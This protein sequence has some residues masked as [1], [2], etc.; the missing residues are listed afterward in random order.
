MAYTHFT[1]QEDGWKKGDSHKSYYQGS[2]FGNYQFVTLHDIVDNFMISYVGENKIIPTVRRF[3]VAFHA[4]RALQELSFD[5]LKSWKS[6]QI[7]LPPTLV[8]TLPHDYIAYTKISTVDSAGI[9]HPLYPT[10]H[11]SNPFQIMQ[12]E[13]GSYEFP[14]GVELVENGDYSDTVNTGWTRVTDGNNLP[15]LTG[16]NTSGPA[17]FRSCVNVEDDKLKWSYVTKNGQGAYN[18]SHICFVYQEINVSD[19]DYITLSADG[20]S[21]NVSYTA[22]DGTAGTLSST[23]R[24]GVTSTKPQDSEVKNVVGSTTGYPANPNANIDIFDLTSPES[25]DPTD[26]NYSAGGSH[27]E[28]SGDEAATKEIE[29]IDVRNYNTV[30]VVALSIVETTTFLGN[31]LAIKANSLDNVSVQSTNASV[32]L[33]SPIENR[34][35][36]STWENYKS[37]SP[38]ENNSHDY[39]DYENDIY[40]PNQGERYG[41]DPQHAQINGS[42]YVDERIGRIHFSS[43][44]SG[45]TVILDYISDSLGTDQETM[46]HKFAEEAMYKSIAHAVISTSSFGQQLVPRFKKEKFA[47]VRQAKL[48]LSNIKLEEFT[49][50]LRGKSKQIKH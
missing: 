29:Y 10:K 28:W 5:T 12:E 13:D 48:R 23:V 34:K 15:L 50:I 17:R 2:N 33:Q 25:G 38:S 26:A 37:H 30:F 16:S 8:M 1:N 39:Q 4:H 6:Q 11:T 31:G 49:Q 43:N 22:Q 40:W 3:D 46:V 7:E 24:V 21:E 36:S 20:V 18:W 42:F 44:I 14:S 45:K 47:A 27:I 9:K 19:L 35:N 32:N 41:L